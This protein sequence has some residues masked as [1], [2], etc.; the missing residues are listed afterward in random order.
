MNE[1][2]HSRRRIPRFA[3]RRAA[4]LSNYLGGLLIVLAAA[5]GCNA[6]PKPIFP[7]IDPPIVWPKPPDTPRI[8]YIGELT[9]Q[10]SLGVQ[11]SGWDALRA[12]V[13]GPD[14]RIAFSAP[15]AVAVRGELV[16]VTDGQ[17]GVVHVLDLGARTFRLITEAAGALLEGPIDVVVAGD[18][19]AVADSRRGAVFFYG[20][21]GRY[22]GRSEE[23]ALERPVALG[24][25]SAAS[26]LWV[27]DAAAHCCVLFDARGQEKMRIG[28]RGFG[29]GQF[30]YP[31]GMTHREPFG[32]A[33][34]DSMNF[35]VQL[36]DAT[37]QLFN[38]FGQKGDAAGDFALPR[39]VAIDSDSHVYVLDNQFENVQVFDRAGQLLM[40]FGREGHG[41]GEFY[42]PT[43]ITL[44][45]QD[46]IWIADTYNRRVQV[47]QYLSED[48]L[49]V[50]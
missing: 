46:R 40:A 17:L 30:N 38:I 34:A 5:S 39:D 13:K 12:I 16:F 45:E 7:T 14:P 25:N 48:A 23:G 8:R 28:Q 15:N 10:A 49:W 26:E 31:A 44:D 37:G 36:F 35:R 20:L 1:V 24:W 19:I 9:G 33:V 4:V 11:P 27:L 50:Q 6:T 32:L 18:R 41:P 3:T 42:L 43:G 21:D 22:L 2:F 47:F 29:P